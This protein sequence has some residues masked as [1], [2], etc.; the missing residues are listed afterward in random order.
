[1]IQISYVMR[2]SSGN[3][4]YCSVDFH[5]LAVNRLKE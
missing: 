5:G 1:M 2:V 3:E 4:T